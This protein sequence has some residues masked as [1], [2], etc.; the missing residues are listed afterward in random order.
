[1]LYICSLFL[2]Y[3]GIWAGV[4][5]APWLPISGLSAAAKL[6]LEMGIWSHDGQVF[7]HEPG[8]IKWICLYSMSSLGQ[9]V[10]L[11][12]SYARFR[13]ERGLG[14]GTKLGQSPFSPIVL[15]YGNFI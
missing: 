9:Y 11:L 14:S 3:S 15:S 13:K 8:L 1:V 6:F 12:L 10:G 7:I 5:W 2:S 4:Q